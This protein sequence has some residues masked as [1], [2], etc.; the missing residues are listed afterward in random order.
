MTLKKIIH[1]STVLSSDSLYRNSSLL[2]INNAVIAVVGFIFWILAAR[3]YPTHEVGVATTLISITSLLSTIS[4]LG[5]NTSLIRLIPDSKNKNGLISYALL[6]VTVASLIV[7]VLFFILNDRLVPALGLVFADRTSSL[8]IIVFIILNSINAITD[9]IFLAY[10]SAKYTLL[11]NIGLVVFKLGLPILLVG[12]GGLGIFF[13]HAVGIIVSMLI[14]CIFLYSYL[15]Y[16]PS[17]H[18]AQNEIRK[19]NNVSLSNHILYFLQISPVMLLPIIITNQVGP[20]QSAYFYLAMTIASFVFLIPNIITNSMFAES[21][22]NEVAIYSHTRKALN[23]ISLTLIPAAA[24]VVIFSS[25]IL[26]IYGDEFSLQSSEPLRILAVSSLFL[27][28]NYIC[29]TILR[30]R[31]QLNR[32]ILITAVGSFSILFISFYLASYSLVLVSCA[33]LG[34]Q[35]LMSV[36]YIL[37]IIFKNKKIAY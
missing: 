21:S 15:G 8:F 24:L 35:A 26:K 13:A 14:S 11:A 17:K 25:L 32:A 34:G 22:T 29:L 10:R 37:T 36:L 27:S 19:I 16:R 9:S 6:M 4:Y 12:Y 1:L 2:L 31:Y 7:A 28:I 30:I 20:T 5:F 33:W 23:L 3:W 18:I